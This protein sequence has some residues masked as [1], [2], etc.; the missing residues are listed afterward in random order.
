M[1]VQLQGFELV[2]Y[3]RH[4]IVDPHEPIHPNLIAWRGQ[5]TVLDTLHDIGAYEPQRGDIIQ[6]TYGAGLL[7]FNVFAAHWRPVAED[8]RAE[9]GYLGE[10]QLD[11]EP[12]STIWTGPFAMLVSGGPSYLQ[13]CPTLDGCSITLPDILIEQEG[14]LRPRIVQAQVYQEAREEAAKVWATAPH[15]MIAALDRLGVG[16]NTVL[17]EMTY[18]Y[19]PYLPAGG[20]P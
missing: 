20:P 17:D 10:W 11:A 4:P 16:C 13:V 8:A 9:C 15:T 12:Y 5:W 3:L 6:A 14:E 7:L 19:L 18:A 2:T 1:T